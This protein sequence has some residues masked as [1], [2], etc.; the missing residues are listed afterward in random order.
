MG[1]IQWILDL[2]SVLFD[3]AITLV[4]FVINLISGLINLIINIP[5]Y[6]EVIVN[7]VN[8]LPAY[9]TPFAVAYLTITIVHFITNRQGG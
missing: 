1:A 2:F 5:T 3:T 4:N 7:C 9:I 8:F 6:L